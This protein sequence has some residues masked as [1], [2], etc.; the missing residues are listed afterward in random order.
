[1]ISSCWAKYFIPQCPQTTTTHTP[2]SLPRPSMFLAVWNFSNKVRLPPP[3]TDFNEV[4]IVGSPDSRE[5]TTATEA[6]QITQRGVHNSNP[7]TSQVTDPASNIKIQTELLPSTSK[8][9]G[10]VPDPLLAGHHDTPCYYTL[11]DTIYLTRT[12]ARPSPKPPPSP[13]L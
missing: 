9:I 7:Q 1:M 10:G 4:P 5:C 2:R 13:N 6:L 8:Q 11:G 3:D 12:P